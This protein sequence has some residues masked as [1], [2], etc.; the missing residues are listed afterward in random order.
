MVG[1]LAPPQIV[2]VHAGQVIMNQTH[3][4]D[5]LQRNGGGHGLLLSPAKHFRGGQTQDGADAL[6]PG[7]EAIQH[8]FADFFGLRADGN[9]GG[10]EGR[11]DHRL[12]GE[13]VGV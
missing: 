2:V 6:P 7:H 5:H 4:V 10:L 11:L 13:E 8:G 12:L 3:G 1:R 9:D